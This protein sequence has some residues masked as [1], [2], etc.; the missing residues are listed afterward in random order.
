MNNLLKFYFHLRYY[1]RE[2]LEGFIIWALY[3]FYTNAEVELSDERIELE[4]RLAV[5]SL[6]LKEFSF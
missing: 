3:L 6:K 2:D 1:Q 4:V 5:R